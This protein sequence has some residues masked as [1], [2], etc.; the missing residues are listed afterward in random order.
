MLK[1]LQLREPERRCWLWYADPQTPGWLF[2]C[3]S[4]EGLSKE[5][6]LGCPQVMAA[7]RMQ[8]LQLSPDWQRR[9][10]D[11]VCTAPGAHPAPKELLFINIFP[12]HLCLQQGGRDPDFGLPG[13]EFLTAL[14]NQG[15]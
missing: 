7:V 14:F 5:K 1:F 12:L 11:L 2:Q 13:E 3:R 9:F 15:I 6:L 10:R 4:G 8:H